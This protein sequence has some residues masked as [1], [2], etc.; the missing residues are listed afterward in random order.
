[1]S[2]RLVVQDLSKHYG[3][4]VALAPTDL[5]LR[6]GETVILSGQNGSGKTTLLTCI[7]N[8][9]KPSSGTV[10]VDSF[11]M[12]SSEIE[13]RKRLVFVPDVQRF[14]ITMTVWEHLR[15][16][17]MANN[18]LDGFD[19][20]AEALLREFGLW[21]T[22]DNFPHNYSRGMKLKLSLAMAFIRPFTVLLLDEPTSALDE[23]SVELLLHKLGDLRQQGTSILMSS[24]NPL[25]KQQFGDRQFLVEEGVMK[26]I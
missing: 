8:L 1:M 20:R 16:I 14:Y 21:R 22:K 4:F 13:V 23:E 12:A 17:A 9:V 15:F 3:N 6:A 2:D 26:E 18:V 5:T 25:I 19:Q 7:A 24:H 11:D 10:T